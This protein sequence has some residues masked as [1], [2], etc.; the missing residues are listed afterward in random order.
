MPLWEHPNLQT[1]GDK[2]LREQLNNIEQM[3][4]KMNKRIDEMQTDMEDSFNE[5]EKQLL[6]LHKKSIEFEEYI[7]ECGDLNELR[8][9]VQNNQNN[10]TQCLSDLE[11]SWLS[12]RA[13]HEIQNELYEINQFIPVNKVYAPT[14]VGQK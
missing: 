14:M 7:N 10:I 5:I 1:I 6:E 3:L 4:E 13:V 12:A 8:E 9:T 11:E 2:M